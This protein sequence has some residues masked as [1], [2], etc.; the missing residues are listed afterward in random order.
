L[1]GALALWLPSGIYKLTALV[2]IGLGAI[3]LL[4]NIGSDSRGEPAE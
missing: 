3:L 4:L 2:I 1:F